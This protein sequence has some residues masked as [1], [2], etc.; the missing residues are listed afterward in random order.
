[1]EEEGLIIKNKKSRH[2]QAIEDSKRMGL[3]QELPKIVS[4]LMKNVNKARHNQHKIDGNL[5]AIACGYNK[6]Y[7]Y[8]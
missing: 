5:Y 1:M 2:Q 3:S 8:L 4:T 6:P 7:P